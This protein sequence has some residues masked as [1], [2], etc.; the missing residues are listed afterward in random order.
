MG[1]EMVIRTQNEILDGRRHRRSQRLVLMVIAGSL[2][3]MVIS[4]LCDDLDGHSSMVIAGSSQVSSSMVIAG[5]FSNGSF[6]KR[7]QL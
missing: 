6:E 7:Y 3:L 1:L 2:V 5:L 4:G